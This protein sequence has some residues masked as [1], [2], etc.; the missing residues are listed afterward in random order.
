VEFARDPG[1]SPIRAGIGVICLLFLQF[2][3][4]LASAQSAE[5]PNYPVIVVDQGDGIIA[6]AGEIDFRTPLAFERTL[7]E[8]PNASVLILDSPGGAVHGALAIASRVRGL[9]MTT[10]ILSENKCFS[11]CA[12]VFFAGANRWAFGELGVHQIS[13]SNGRGDMVGGQFA[14]ADVIEALNEYDVPSEVISVMLRTP[15]DGMYVFSSSENRR[16]GF[17]DAAEPQTNSPAVSSWAVDLAN[18]VTWRGKT[19]TGQLVASGKKWYASLNKDGTTTFRFTSG[20]ISTGRYYIS[21]GEVCFQL[22]GNPEFSC[23]RPVRGPGV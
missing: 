10:V 13:P 12:L 14:L 8:V 18:P 23:R 16:F 5:Y 22:D 19:V 20:R 21:E 11:A 7:S 4:S 6:I 9:G 15:P 3:A 2:W 17:L 1:I